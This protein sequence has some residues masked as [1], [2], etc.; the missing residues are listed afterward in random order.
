[1]TT[2]QRND[3]VSTGVSVPALPSV[4]LILEALAAVQDRIQHKIRTACETFGC[5][6]HEIHQAFSSSDEQ[7]WAEWEREWS[8]VLDGNETH[9]IFTFES[10]PKQCEVRVRGCL[11]YDGTYGYEEL[12]SSERVVE[13]L[14]EL[15]H[16]ALVVVD[17]LF[18]QLEVDFP[19]SLKECQ[20]APSKGALPKHLRNE[21]MGNE[22]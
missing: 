5:Q 22:G 6:V 13:D 1:M 16:L 14:A 3:R 20:N 18:A 4:S 2:M 21:E 7:G 8:L 9:F 12:R 11:E 10:D 15:K 19:A 17:D